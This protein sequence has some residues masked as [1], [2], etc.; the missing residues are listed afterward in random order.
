MRPQQTGEPNVTSEQ[1]NE[2]MAIIG[3]TSAFSVVGKTARPLWRNNVSLPPTMRHQRCQKSSAHES[4][5]DF[6]HSIAQSMT[7]AWATLT[8]LFY[9]AHARAC[10]RDRIAVGPL[11]LYWPPGYEC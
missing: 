6:F 10:Y 3:P 9:P 8:Q 7:K 4:A 5:K 2:S 11:A 1:T